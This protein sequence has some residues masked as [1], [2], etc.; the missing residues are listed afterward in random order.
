MVRDITEVGTPPFD[1]ITAADWERALFAEVRCFIGDPALDEEFSTL[2][3]DVQIEGKYPE[4]ALAVRYINRRRGTEPVLLRFPLWASDE[5]LGPDGD[6]EDP[7]M[8][9]GEIYVR[10]MEGP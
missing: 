8:S 2:V 10:L 9:A 4:S 7:A 6:L 5:F 1:R 3:L